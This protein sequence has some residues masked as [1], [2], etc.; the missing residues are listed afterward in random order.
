LSSDQ[1]AASHHGQQ[2][3]LQHLLRQHI[4]ESLVL[5]RRGD[6]RAVTSNLCGCRGVYARLYMSV[7]H[8]GRWLHGMSLAAFFNIAIRPLLLALFH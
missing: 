2:N 8:L 1:A 5:E 3:L 4:D 6:A 7:D